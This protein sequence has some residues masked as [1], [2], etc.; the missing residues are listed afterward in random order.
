MKVGDAMKIIASDFDN[1]IYYLK[2]DKRSIHNKQNVE[3]INN[4]INK[5]NIFDLAKVFFSMK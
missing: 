4:F 1:T 2:D 5:G 3:S